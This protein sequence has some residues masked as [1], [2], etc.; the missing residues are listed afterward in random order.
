MYDQDSQDPETGNS[1]DG[2]DLMRR[3]NGLMGTANRRL[4]ERDAAIAERD[5]ARAELEALRA[6]L[7]STPETPY[8]QVINP[9][10]RRAETNPLEALRDST[11]QDFGIEGP[12]TLRG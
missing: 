9:M 5:A 12:V 4:S 2:N 8:R 11:W 1:Q 7:D 6:Q 10:K 3:V